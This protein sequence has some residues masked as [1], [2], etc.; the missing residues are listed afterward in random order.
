MPP[1]LLLGTYTGGA[2]RTQVGNKGQVSPT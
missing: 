2:F 1:L